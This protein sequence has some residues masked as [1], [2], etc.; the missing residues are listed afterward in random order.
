MAR[1]SSDNDVIRSGAPVIIQGGNFVIASNCSPPENLAWSGFANELFASKPINLSN[2]SIGLGLQRN[3]PRRSENNFFVIRGSDH[4]FPSSP[5]CQFTDALRQEWRRHFSRNTGLLEENEK[6]AW[7]EFVNFVFQLPRAIIDRHAQAAG[8]L[9]QH[10]AMHI[11]GLDRR[12]AWNE[13]TFHEVSTKLVGQIAGQRAKFHP[14]QICPWWRLIRR[15]RLRPGRAQTVNDL[16]Q[17][18][19]CGRA[20]DKSRIW[21]AVEIPNPNAQD[22]MIEYRN[23][24]GISKPVRGS[25]FPMNRRAVIAIGAI[26][27]RSW[28]VAEHFQSKKRRFWR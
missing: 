21:S 23:G 3:R 15:A 26:Q 12:Q 13:P 25:R 4:G 1:L 24:P 2:V 10:F 11:A 17:Q 6:F 18:W 9:D 20:A 14:F 19:R 16:K 5:T 27:F 28:H 7:P 22:V 8:G